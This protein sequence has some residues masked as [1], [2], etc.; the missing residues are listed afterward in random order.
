MNVWRLFSRKKKALIHLS[1]E[2][3][4]LSPYPF[5]VERLTLSDGSAIALADEGKG[6]YTLFFIHGL[7][8]SMLVW[9]RNLPTLAQHFRCVAI[10]LP[11]YG[12]SPKGRR[13]LDMV[14]LSSIISEAIYR[15]GL[16][17]VVLVGHSMGGQ[18]AMMTALRYPYTIQRLVLAAPAGFETFNTLQKVALRRGADP[19]AVRRN[20]PDQ[21]EKNL[22]FSF[23]RY[24]EEAAFMIQDRIDIIGSAA[25]DDYCLTV[26]ESIKAMI[27]GEVW[28]NLHLIQSPTQV[29]FGA[30]DPLIPNRLFTPLGRTAQVA[31]AGTARIPRA[32]LTLLEQCGHFVPFEQAELFNQGVKQFL[33]APR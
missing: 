28:P 18:V 5:D 19:A 21:I 8:S 3:P 14:Y 20:T 29:F 22:K 2:F 4:H 32:E 26:S 7:A 15:K 16:K 17:N 6:P 9:R 24:D 27:N 23:Y 11:G 10:D 1:R 13:P 30:N 12:A 25:F 33:Q 31:Q